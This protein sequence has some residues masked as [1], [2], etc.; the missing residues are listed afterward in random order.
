VPAKQRVRRDDGRDL[1]QSSTAQPIRAHGESAT[2][3]VG[4]L[5]ASA[6]Q[7][8]AKHTILFEQIPKDITLLTSSHPVRSVSSNWNAERSITAGVYITTSVVPWRVDPVMG[9][10]GHRPGGKGQPS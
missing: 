1:P 7:L 2:I 5:Q 3:V 10:Y 6:P 4:H 9:Q 8:T